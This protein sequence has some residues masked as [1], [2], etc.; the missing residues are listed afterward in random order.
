MSHA[1]SA[2]S[3][4]YMAVAS[5]ACAA[6]FYGTLKRLPAHVRVFRDYSIA[7]LV[8]VTL[9]TL[10]FAFACVQP[11]LRSAVCEELSRQPE[12]MRNLA[13]TGLNIDNCE[14]YF[15]RGVVG[16][17]AVMSVLLICR[18]QFTLLVTDYYSQLLR[19][20]SG[21]DYDELSGDE[22]G[23]Q[24]KIYL[25][26]SR[27]TQSKDGPLIYAPLPRLSLA[28]ARQ[29]RATEAY[30]SRPSRHS[31]SNSLPH[32]HSHSSHSHSHSHRRAESLSSSSRQGGIA[33]PIR[34]G[35]GLVPERKQSRK[36]SA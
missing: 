20:G 9:S 14:V 27:D 33:L 15:E 25:L 34:Q 6:G 13:D 4:V 10:M 35:E 16:I 24:Q 7:D 30:V 22:S 11:T 23:G 1:H 29:M 21:A 3:S 17:V 2:P 36:Q 31:H 8:F 18:M 28:D 26:P 5:V 19:T 32:H 12:L